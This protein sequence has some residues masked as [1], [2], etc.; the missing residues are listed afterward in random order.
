MK[1]FGEWMYRATILEISSRWMWE[2]SFTPW[3]L[4]PR[5]KR[6]VFPLVRRLGGGSESVWTLWVKEKSLPG[7]EPWQY[8]V[9][10]PTEIFQLKLCSVEYEVVANFAVLSQ[11]FHGWIEKPART[12]EDRWSL[13]PRF[14]FEKSLV[15]IRNIAGNFEIEC[16][17]E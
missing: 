15:R 14:G 4:Y 13:G 3:P 6:S 11:H 7:I 12:L 10:I 9:A 5:V 17:W 8:P 2:V 16:D 1:A